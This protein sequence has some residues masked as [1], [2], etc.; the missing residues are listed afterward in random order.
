MHGRS[1][2]HSPRTGTMKVGNISKGFFS[3]FFF[4]FF[5]IHS[6]NDKSECNENLPVHVLVHG[7]V[8]V[9]LH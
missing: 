9:E 3:F 5:L 4:F 1:T 8:A 6:N 7:C 2:V